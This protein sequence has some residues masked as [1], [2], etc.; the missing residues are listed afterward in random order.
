[1][2]VLALG[3]GL[4][5]LA[6][7]WV[8][9]LPAQAE[10]SFTAHMVMHM[11]VVAVAAPLLAFGLVGTRADPLRGLSPAMVALPAALFEL[12]VVWG[13][14]APAAHDAVRLSKP[15]LVLEQG[16]FLAA[17]LAVWLAALA[18]VGRVGAAGRGAGVLCLLLTSMH[19]TLLGALLALAPRVL[20][21]CLQLCA[22]NTERT[23]LEDQSL[24]GVVM[25][26][27]G[28]VSYLIGGLAVMAPLLR[29]RLP[30]AADAESMEDG[31]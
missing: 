22:A 6:M 1:M 31:R 16:S 18:P 24:G 13:W 8:G 19:M 29:E 12:V 7:L 9:P 28:G 25:L 20:Y 5:L 10:V 14:H 3:L 11:G 26:A 4:L 17:G 21:Q 15:L 2:R 27:V 23:P 30:S